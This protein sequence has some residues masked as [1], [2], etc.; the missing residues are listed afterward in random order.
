MDIVVR[1]QNIETALERTVFKGGRVVSPETGEIVLDVNTA[2]IEDIDRFMAMFD[3]VSKGTK[4]VLGAVKDHFLKYRK[5][6]KGDLQSWTIAERKE[7][8][9]EPD[10]ED[11]RQ[12]ISEK[13]RLEADLKKVKDQIKELEKSEGITYITKILR[14]RK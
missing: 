2:P 6:G 3:T 4:D 5:V 1:N 8:T 7:Y 11:F 13:K 9:V 14:R 12:L 10:N